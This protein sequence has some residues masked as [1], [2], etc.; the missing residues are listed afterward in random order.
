MH[1]ILMIVVGFFTIPVIGAFITCYIKETPIRAKKILG[2]L[3]VICLSITSYNAYWV[4]HDTPEEIAAKKAQAEISA[5]RSACWD[6]YARTDSKRKVATTVVVFEFNR[7][8]KSYLLQG[9][10]DDDLI[11]MFCD[12]KSKVVDK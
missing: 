6:E 11:G 5:K 10:T 12:A 9:K 8:D 1:T 7:M 2:S 3:L 4:F